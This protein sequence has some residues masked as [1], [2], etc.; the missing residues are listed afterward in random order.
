MPYWIFFSASSLKH[1]VGGYVT[2]LRH[3]ITITSQTVLA[4]TP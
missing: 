3:I 4:L 1:S 2:P